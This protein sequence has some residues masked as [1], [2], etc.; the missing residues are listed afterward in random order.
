MFS[1][2]ECHAVGVGGWGRG[3]WGGGGGFWY[4]VNLYGSIRKSRGFSSVFQW[5]NV[6]RVGWAGGGG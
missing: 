2:V 4:V 5:L 1:M 3:G 6:M